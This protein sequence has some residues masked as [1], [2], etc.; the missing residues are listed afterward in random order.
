MNEDEYRSIIDY[1]KYS[2]W[3][4]IRC[5]I[6]TVDTCLL[7][8]DPC[9]PLICDVRKRWPSTYRL[10]YKL[11]RSFFEGQLSVVP[12]SRILKFIFDECDFNDDTWSA[13]IKDCIWRKENQ[14]MRQ[15]IYMRCRNMLINDEYN[16]KLIRVVEHFE[17][18]RKFDTWKKYN[19]VLINKTKRLP[20]EF[21]E[22]KPEVVNNNKKI[23]KR[24]V[25]CKWT[26]GKLKII[27]YT[28]MKH[29]HFE[30]IKYAM[31]ARKERKFVFTIPCS[32]VC[33]LIKICKEEG[34]MT[35]Q[36]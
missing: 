3:R 26:I 31:A 24:N 29:N 9:T 11:T 30:S 32:I 4:P 28:K 2:C 27:R 18:L 35:W 20:L 10:C 22:I 13:I 23:A 19:K 1:Y 17:H 8:R 33:E 36:K 25:L 34:L 7:Y 15:F 16:R 21:I 5:N 14:S 12:S 6:F